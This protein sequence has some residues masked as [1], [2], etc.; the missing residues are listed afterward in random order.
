MWRFGIVPVLGGLLHRLMRGEGR[1]RGG[2]V[3]GLLQGEGGVVEGGGGGG[4]EGEVGGEGAGAGAVGSRP[5]AM[6]NAGQVRE[7]MGRIRA[8]TRN[9]IN[10][11]FFCHPP[12]VLNNAREV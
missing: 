3:R 5:C 1:W 10:L 2:R 11:N 9:P 12:P 7:Q 4:M 6:L 8:R